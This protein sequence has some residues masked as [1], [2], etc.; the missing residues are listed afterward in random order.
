MNVLFLKKLSFLCFLTAAFGTFADS[1][2]GISIWGSDEICDN[3]LDDDGDGLTDLNDPDC[4]CEIVSY[5]SLI[6]NP[7]FEVFS[8]CPWK[9]TQMDCVDGWSQASSATTDYMN[10]CG[11]T[12][13]GFFD[14][15]L[16]IPDGNACLR[17]IDGHFIT[18]SGAKAP[19]K[20]YA[21]VCLNFPMKKGTTYRFEFDLGFIEENR[22]PDINISFFGSPACGNL[23]FSNEIGFDCPISYPNWYFLAAKLIQRESGNHWKKVDLEITPAFDINAIAVGPSCDNLVEAPKSLYYFL[24]NFNLKK[25]DDFDFE[26]LES[27]SPCA[28]DF[29]FAVQDQPTHSYQWYKEGIAIVGETAAQLSA[30]RGEGAYQLRI[31]NVQGCRVSEDYIYARPVSTSALAETICTGATFLFGDRQLSEGGTYVETFQTVD[32]CDS[33][34]SLNLTVSPP[35]LDT[36]PMQILPGSAIEFNTVRYYAEGE[37]PINFTTAAGCDSIIVLQLTLSDLYIPNIFSPNDD[38]LNDY[39]RVL[40]AAEEIET[41]ELS[42]YDRWG[43]LLFTGEEWDGFRNGEPMGE[44]VYVYRVQ[45]STK[46]GEELM[47][48]GSL[49][50]VR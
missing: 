22:S 28:Q 29:A 35:S 26:L 1:H 46:L 21:G 14:P 20:E 12:G 27:G 45:I 23:P 10:L 37:Y 47:Y 15:P 6:P 50:L 13:D 8:C 36:V 16:P 31:T 2:N 42:I 25:S 9:E 32:N 33:I 19:Y 44:G 39:F 24:D 34:V 48:A 11:W 7:S 4:Q 38:G 43:G 17:F 30:M 5:Q 18:P 49:T 3:A 41:V 40:G